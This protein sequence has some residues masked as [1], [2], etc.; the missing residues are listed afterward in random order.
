MKLEKKEKR[1]EKWPVKCDLA[2][3]R[4]ETDGSQ[5]SLTYSDA[6]NDSDDYKA[7]STYQRLVLTCCLVLDDEIASVDCHGC[8][9]ETGGLDRDLESRPKSNHSDV[10]LWQRPT[11][12]HQSKRERT[13]MRHEVKKFTK[14]S[15]QL[16]VTVHVE[17]CGEWNTKEDEEE[18]GDGQIEDVEVGDVVQFLVSNAQVNDEAIADDAEQSQEGPGRADEQL[19]AERVLKLFDGGSER[20]ELGLHQVGSIR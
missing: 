3:N 1:K 18:I 11:V 10:F 17:K 20:R 4:S 19:E 14:D 12:T 6:S 15:T 13:Y 5:I 16:P 7:S 2:G 9:N 8:Q